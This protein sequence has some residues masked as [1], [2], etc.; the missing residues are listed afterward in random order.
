MRRTALALLA[1]LA[2][3]AAAP[4][5]AA[6]QRSHSSRTPRNWIAG[7]IGAALGGA[8]AGTYATLSGGAIG[9]CSRPKCVSIL[10]VGTGALVGFMIGRESDRLYNLRY[11]FGRPI[12]LRG[13]RLDLAFVP[14]DVRVH[15]PTVAV[16]GEGGVEILSGAP[17][18]ER[19]TTRGRGLRGVQLAEPER[20]RLLVGTTIG[21]Y[22]FP[23]GGDQTLGALLAPGE[24]S[25]LDLRGERILIASGRQVAL[26]SALNDSLRTLGESRVFGSP[27]VDIAWD[28]R[29]ELAWVLTESALVAVAVADT[30]L[31]DSVGAFAL[32]AP[33]R[34]LD[35][36][37]DTAAVAAGEGGVFL[38]GVAEPRAPVVLAQWSGARFAYDVALRG[39]VVYLAA[40]PEGLYVLD[41]GA[42]GNFA[43]RGLDRHFGF[44]ASLRV[45][46]GELY[47]V[48]RA[49]KAL[50]RVSLPA[51]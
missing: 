30:A 45:S 42:G 40:G 41:A 48:D 44:V 49:G 51:R 12:T 50:H 31:G 13:Q 23:L 4:P 24:V 17:R 21:L 32:P 22:A 46:N 16:A 8:A 25:A 1:V 26:A 39:G 14:L 38:L 29:R 2:V 18:L 19:V 20:E 15:G 43:V 35:L 33:G 34:R 36:E 9:N 37:G 47:V 6:A 7:L 27:V 5:W 3:L 10:S 28:A 11:R